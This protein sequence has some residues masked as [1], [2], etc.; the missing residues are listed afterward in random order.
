MKSNF[1]SSVTTPICHS[2][3]HFAVEVT[4]AVILLHEPIMNYKTHNLKIENPT[5][6]NI[7]VWTPPFIS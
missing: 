5:W 3:F 1:T 2:T 7:L 4:R 6:Y